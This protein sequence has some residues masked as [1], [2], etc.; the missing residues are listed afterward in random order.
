MPAFKYKGRDIEGKLVE[1]ILEAENE[2]SLSGKLGELD[3]VLVESSQVRST[4]DR[5]IYFG[6][7][8]RRE[9]ILFTNH[10]AT[11]TEAGVSVVQA[12]SDFAIETTNERFKKIVEDVER[13]VLTGT[14]LSEAL[15]KHPEAFSELYVSVVATGEATGR[16]E[17]SLRDLVGFLEWQE[18]LASQVK[19][20]SIYPTFLISMIIGVVIIMMTFTFPKFIPVFRSFQ[21]ELPAPTVILI[22]VSEFFQAYWWLFPLTVILFLIVYKIT[23]KSP[24]GKFFW[25]RIKLN[26]PL[27]G[28][29]IQ[30]IILSRFAHYFSML[31]SSGIGIIESFNIIQRVVGNEV[32]RRAV[33]RCTES[34]QV[35]GTIFD[36]LKKEK[37]FP[38]LVLRMLQVGEKTGSLDKSLQKVS[39]YYDKEVPAAVKKMFAVFEPMLIILMGGVVLFIALA[40]FL[41]IYKLTSSIGGSR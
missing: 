3:V 20:A 1:G 4:E 41:P 14:T 31:Y 39:E 27:F 23:Y 24:D 11:S 6:K 19:Q 32:V 15:A 7:L 33:G 25:D 21:V 17:A 8:K 12:I 38:P 30:K 35:G 10:L 40:I 36:S 13:Q 34:V 16:L 28:V 22:S 26:I 9:I 29:L 37:T 5:T 2:S 18:D